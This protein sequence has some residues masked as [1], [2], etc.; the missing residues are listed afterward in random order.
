MGE[1]DENPEMASWTKKFR[2]GPNR[3]PREP[4]GDTELDPCLEGVGSGG[5]GRPNP[6][7]ISPRPPDTPYKRK[8]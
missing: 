2:V 6:A 4:A 1:E 5:K 7:P 8:P 3:A